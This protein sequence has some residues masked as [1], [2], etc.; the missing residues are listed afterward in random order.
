[1]Q[2]NAGCARRLGKGENGPPGSSG[3]RRKNAPPPAILK[4]ADLATPTMATPTQQ[5]GREP[6]AN[7]LKPT[8]AQ[9]AGE[10]ERTWTMRRR[11]TPWCRFRGNGHAGR[12]VP[13]TPCRVRENACLRSAGS[14]RRDVVIWGHTHIPS[15]PSSTG[16]MQGSRTGVPNSISLRAQSG[17]CSTWGKGLDQGGRGQLDAGA[18]G[19]ILPVWPGSAEP[20]VTISSGD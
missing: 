20:V 8:P 5:R 12:R 4:E 13:S 15:E 1:M 3:R 14:A 9:I 16:H 11:Q 10:A 6:F 17:L 18:S 2:V 7:F 19:G